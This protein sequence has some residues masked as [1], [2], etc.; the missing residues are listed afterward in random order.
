MLRFITK[1]VAVICALF[2]SSCFQHEM[3]ITL[4]KDG[5]GTVVEE[6]RMG[7]QMLAML[8][9]L[10]A[11]FGGEEGVAQ[12]PTA[13]LLSEDK[14]KE[15]A[16]ELGEGVTL[17]KVEPVEQDGSKGARITYAFEDI[18][19]LNADLGSGM[20]SMAGGGE[21]ADDEEGKG[22]KQSPI[23]FH[24]KDGKLTI[25][26]PKP[27]KDD[28]EVVT[29]EE[30]DEEAIGMMKQVFSDM[31]MS[32]KLVIA[33]GIADTNATHRDGDTITLMAV[34]FGKLVGDAESL[35]KLAATH[36]ETDPAKRVEA[37]KGIEGVEIEVQPQVT[38]TLK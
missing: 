24:Y 25:N 38:V 16:K 4:N 15:R 31:K 36:N 9:Q 26:M 30:P 17:V 11:G 14:A 29:Q 10:A 22:L 13:D 19:K 12:D 33:P 28:D 6:S 27:E 5:S 37:L 21:V 3:T 1:T 34:D 2:L 32:I 7:A 35:K 20:N 18:N 23:G 8:G